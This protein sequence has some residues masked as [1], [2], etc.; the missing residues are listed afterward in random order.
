MLRILYSSSLIFSGVFLTYQS[1]FADDPKDLPVCIDLTNIAEISACKIVAQKVLKPI[2]LQ[3][4]DV[5]GITSF[6]DISLI[7][8]NITAGSGA[9]LSPLV[10]KGI[11]DLRKGRVDAKSD[12][13]VRGCVNISPGFLSELFDECSIRESNTPKTWAASQSAKLSFTRNF[14]ANEDNETQKS[15][16]KIASAFKGSQGIDGRTAMTFGTEYNRNTTEGEKLDNL[17]IS[18]GIVRDLF[19]NFNDT[20]DQVKDKLVEWDSSTI[21]NDYTSVQFSGDFSYNRKGVYGDLKSD[22]C[23]AMP[24]AKYCGKQILET[25]RFTGYFVPYFPKLNS[26]TVGE[27]NAP[28]LAWSISPSL[29]FFVDDAL[30]G[31]VELPMDKNV[32]GTVYGLVANV[33]AGISPGISKNRWRLSA[34]GQIVEALKRS[35]GRVSTFEDT[36]RK[37]STTLSYALAD[38]AYVKQKKAKNNIVPAIS[39]TYTNGSDSLIGKSSQDTLEVAFS[40][41]Y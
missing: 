12:K 25:G 19:D 30:N 8:K 28:E 39:L 9:K 7:N 36:S 11:E 20:S 38:H 22:E 27:K 17:S 31:D 1:G 2:Q 15:S 24:N 14:D 29:G 4:A 41:L 40:L 16:V 13:F 37:F 3:A 32:N 21:A 34:S 33:S 10:L 26:V 6:D 5:P 18:I 35:E 23:V